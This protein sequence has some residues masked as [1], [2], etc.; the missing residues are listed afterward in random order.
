[1][2]TKVNVGPV[3]VLKVVTLGNLKRQNL[4]LS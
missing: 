3:S 2:V 1:M 4:S